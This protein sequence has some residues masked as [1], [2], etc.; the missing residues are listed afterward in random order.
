MITR[1]ITVDG[2]IDFIHSEEFSQLEPKPIT[3]GRAV[4]QA[5][6]PF[7]SPKDIALVYV[8]DNNKLLAFAGILPEGTEEGEKP[9][10]SNSGWWVHREGG[11]KYGLQV[12]IKALQNSYRRMF[13][14]DCSEHTKAILERTGLF[15]FQKPSAGLRIFLNIYSGDLLR[16]KGYNRVVSNL[17]STADDVLNY[18]WSFRIK[19]WKKLNPH[20]GY[21]IHSVNLIDEELNRYIKK[22][23]SN[24]YLK[25]DGEKLNWIIKYPWIATKGNDLPVSYPFSQVAESFH[26]EFLVVKNE[27]ITVAVLMLS[28]RDHHAS[29]PYIYYS[30]KHLQN[31]II[32]ILNFLLQQKV[33]SL[34][35]FHPE[36][37]K[38]LDKISIPAIFQ[39][40]LSRHSGY[41]KELSGIFSGDK[42]FQDGE[43]DVAFT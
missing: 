24:Y 20:Q 36:I 29:V 25:Q 38:V 31:T 33:N 14:T 41:S 13:F 40:K 42:C 35:I 17:F 8:S 4:S 12:F 23:S 28:I 1:E 7:A 10:F 9:I 34:I 21:T 43:G 27:G 22:H 39:K 32:V 5:N 2:L 3:P 19:A 6:N 26:Q 30:G 11:R 37:L 16:K 15:T 18:L